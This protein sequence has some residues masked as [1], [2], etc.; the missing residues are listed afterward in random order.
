MIT[1]AYNIVCHLINFRITRPADVASLT[2]ASHC[3]HAAVA[4]EGQDYLRGSPSEVH[5]T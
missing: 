4:A 5:E 1:K 2:N 3:H